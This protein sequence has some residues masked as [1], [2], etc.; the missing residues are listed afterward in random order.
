MV[1]A[2]ERTKRV[3][4]AGTQRRSS[5]FL[6][7]AAE[8]VRGGGIGQVTMVSSSHIENQWPNGIIREVG[9]R[10][11]RQW[12]TAAETAILRQHNGIGSR[13]DSADIG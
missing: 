8:L 7:E 9:R 5:P 10:T 1:E 11:V 4:Q 3:V 12:L 6:I 2:A 13:A